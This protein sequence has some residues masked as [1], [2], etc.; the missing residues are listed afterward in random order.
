MDKYLI[1]F[2]IGIS[3]IYISNSY[4]LVHPS[5]KHIKIYA[6]LNIISVSM[7]S[8]YFMHKEKIIK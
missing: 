1:Y 4:M 2:F 5:I 6:I 3:I 7:M 8:Y